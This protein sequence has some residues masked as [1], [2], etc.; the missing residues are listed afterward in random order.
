MS[1]E[2]DDERPDDES[3]VD[4]A[5]ESPDESGDDGETPGETKGPSGPACMDM[6]DLEALDDSGLTI[7]V[8]GL[9][10][11]EPD[12]DEELAIDLS[13]FD[14]EPEDASVVDSELDAARSQADELR[15]E[16]QEVE[17]ELAT[18]R[19]QLRR[20]GADLEN[21]RKRIERDR[22]EEKKHA[23]SGLVLQLLA[24]TDSFQRALEQGES[25]AEASEV[26]GGFV[27]GVR[28]IET[29]FFDI[30]RSA[31]LEPV[32]AEGAFDPAVHEALMQEPSADAPHLSILEVYERGYL[33]GGRLLRPAR[34]KVAHN[35]DGVAPPTEDEASDPPA[36][37]DGGA[38]ETAAGEHEQG[39]DE[40]SR[41]QE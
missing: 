6:A 21:Y 19:D 10:G 14:A 38:D 3:P 1:N 7:E 39:F 12:D 40:P 24:V 31:G 5:D 37:G 35:P 15:H 41:D 2:H 18:V 34:V 26:V 30:L 27:D 8:E 20:T 13:E 25:A 22:R 28:L 9:Q 32:D 33:F 29:Q 36:D 4:S 11:K 23:V 16:K 17:A